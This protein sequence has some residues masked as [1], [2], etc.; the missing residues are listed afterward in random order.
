MKRFIIFIILLPIIIIAQIDSLEYLDYYPLHVGD[1]WVYEII[2][3]GGDDWDTSYQ[4]I[5]VKS[6][7]VMSNGYRYF[8]LS[9]N[10]SYQRLDSISYCVKSYSSLEEKVLY[11][12]C[13]FEGEIDST[14]E[15]FDS[16]T[17]ITYYRKKV[18]GDAGEITGQY[19]KLGYYC[20][21]GGLGGPY[22]ELTKGIGYTK[23][24]CEEAMPY[25]K[26]LIGAEIDGVVYGNISGIESK[27][28][29]P[30]K[31][32]LLSNY[33]NPFNAKTTIRYNL[34]EEGN[35][36]IKIFDI[37]GNLIEILENRV[38]EPGQYSII[39]DA[40]D[41]SSGI[42]VIQMQVKGLTQNRKCLL[43]K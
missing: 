41:N 33:P 17:T 5:T 35:I 31:Y 32:Q 29:L 22:E 25:L 19:E 21:W 34:K 39:W 6:D 24:F 43:L 15:I 11:N 23:Y 26:Q 42:Y 28:N 1:K 20:D 16:I 36:T 18:I 38:K 30:N 8:Y 9:P 14:Q 4:T 2:Q 7:T 10:N 37:L 3:L 40:K 13:P 27:N 12:L